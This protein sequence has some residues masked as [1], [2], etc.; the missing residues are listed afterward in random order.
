M[1]PQ[2]LVMVTLGRRNVFIMVL[3]SP[4]YKDL[5]WIPKITLLREEKLNRG[6]KRQMYFFGGVCTTMPYKHIC[7]ILVLLENN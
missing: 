6:L 1:G 4:Q 5:A 2:L 7:H 3:D